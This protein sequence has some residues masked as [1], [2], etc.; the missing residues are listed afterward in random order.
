MNRLVVLTSLLIFL[1]IVQINVVIGDPIPVDD[2]IIIQP[3][4]II[5]D[6]PLGGVAYIYNFDLNTAKSFELLLENNQ[7]ATDPIPLGTL[8]ETDFVLYQAIIVGSD[9]V[10][11]DPNLV[12]AVGNSGRAI[13]G[14]GEGGYEFLGK[15]GLSIGFPHGW[16]G[17]KTN[18]HIVDPK[19]PIFHD[20]NEIP[21]QPEF[22]ILNLYEETNHVGIHLPEIPIDVTVLGR[23][24]DDISHYPLVLEEDKYILWGFT[25]AP[26]TMTERG[27]QLF[28]NVVRFRVAD[29][30]E[31]PKVALTSPSSGEYLKGVVTLKAEASDINGIAKVEFFYDGTKIGEDRDQPYSWNWDTTT[32]ADDSYKLTAKAWDV[33]GNSATSDGVNV[34]VDD[35]SPTSIITAPSINQVITDEYDIKGTANDRNFERYQLKYGVGEKPISWYDIGDNPRTKPV[36]SDILG[37]WD[38]TDV[39]DGVYTIQLEVEDIVGN[40]L[41]FE[42]IVN[43]ANEPPPFKTLKLPVPTFYDDFSGGLPI[44]SWSQIGWNQ[45]GEIKVIDIGVVDEEI[46]LGDDIE[47][48][49]RPGD[50]VVLFDN[51]GENSGLALSRKGPGMDLSSDEAMIRIWLRSD[52]L[53]STITFGA[54][55]FDEAADPRQAPSFEFL[56]TKEGL[57]T[58]RTNGSPR[59][60]KFE[61]QVEQGIWNNY[62]IMF[63]PTADPQAFDCRIY[64]NGSLIAKVPLDI[65][66]LESRNVAVYFVGYRNPGSNS[67]MYLDGYGTA[68]CTAE[69]NNEAPYGGRITINNGASFTTSRYVTLKILEVYDNLGVNFVGVDYMGFANDVDEDTR[70]RWDEFSSTKNNW[71][72]L[73][74]AE[75]YGEKTVY[76][77]FMDAACNKSEAVPATITLAKTIICSLEPGWNLFSIPGIPMD[78]DLNSL[79]GPD[80]DIIPLLYRWN[81]IG[82]RYVSVTTLNVGEGYWVYTP[83]SETINIPVIPISYEALLPEGWNIIGGVSENADFLNP[84]DNPD[85]CILPLAYGWLPSGSAYV[86]MSTLEPCKG[87]WVLSNADSC[88]LRV[89]DSSLSPAPSQLTNKE[90]AVVRRNAPAFHFPIRLESPDRSIQLVL[91]WDESA[92]PELDPFDRAL[93]PAPPMDEGFE[94]HFEQSSFRLQQD[95]RPPLEGAE[96]WTLRITS[97]DPVKLHWDKTALPDRF[98]LIANTPSGDVDFRATDFLELFQGDYIITLRLE[99]RLPSQSKLPVNFPN[100]FNPETWL[101]YQL[102]EAN[103]VTIT[104]YNVN[105]NKVRTLPLGYKP[106]GYYL[107]HNRAAHWNGRNTNGEE[108]ASGVY[109]YT[110]QAGEFIATRKMVILK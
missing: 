93:P 37:S 20:P 29:D 99:H 2:I 5:V 26:D 38:T 88:T 51:I 68:E 105:G 89:T 95:I 66:Q 57:F 42:V 50:N 110:L 31:P 84:E 106:P 109:F 15:L 14:L 96:T 23:E 81:P 6:I 61:F 34:I 25:G 27:R 48:N 72:L 18:I 63:K 13:I 7:I 47:I 104:I 59:L 30:Q 12:S 79:V 73:L 8:I 74:L 76:A 36:T 80:S 97:N 62:V 44:E 46:K 39:D 103:N 100:P 41:L 77:K 9:T 16:H 45:G 102:S 90:K 35:T 82:S 108:A 22:R 11:N 33:A 10:W 86:N 53:E 52:D 85:G 64:V 58:T 49:D 94:V 3:G 1:I 98:I 21:I 54:F 65:G 56:I 67:S 92:K 107:T 40:I 43:V 28:I 69:T 83:S 4:D 70:Y 71:D 24:I 101:P 17:I 78:T 19:H 87:Y 60:G 91:G 32:V 55:L 75:G